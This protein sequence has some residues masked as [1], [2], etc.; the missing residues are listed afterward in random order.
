MFAPRLARMG[1]HAQP[2]LL[3][4]R[5]HTAIIRCESQAL[6]QAQRHTFAQPKQTVRWFR[7]SRP[8]K[9]DGPVN[10]KS[11]E[12]AE[13]EARQGGQISTAR[14]VVEAGKDAS[15]L[16][17]I[18]FGCGLTAVFAYSLF[19]EL[20]GGTSTNSLYSKS[21]KRVV[22]N[23]RVQE[24]L[25]DNIKAHGEE[26]R[27]GRRRHIASQ[28]YEVDGEVYV[29][30][31]YYVEGSKDTGTVHA[32]VHKKGRSFDYRYLFVEV[33]GQGLPSEHVILED[34]R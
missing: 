3:L 2:A 23:E 24:L 18:L 34:N 15:Y 6:V 14:K 10:A 8:A 17:V 4:A 11:K 5:K 7:T 20:W 29:R 9:H 16:A 28:E 31:R 21:F 26:T 32:E 30:L 19:G 13:W 1:L 33:P 27:R 12:M 25:G 22:A